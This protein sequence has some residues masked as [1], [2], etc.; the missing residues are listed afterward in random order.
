MSVENPQN[1]E[2]MREYVKIRLGHPMIE[3][4]VADQQ[5][6]VRLRQALDL[7][8]EI[9]YNSTEEVIIAHQITA[10]DVSNGF[11]QLDS[12]I[13]QVT[14]I[15]STQATIQYATSGKSKYLISFPH[16]ESG[17]ISMGGWSYG[18]FDQM[19]IRTGPG[20]PL[21][22][23][24]F[25]QSIAEN[26]LYSSSQ[27][28]FEFNLNAKRLFIYDS[29]ELVEGNYVIMRVYQILEHVKPEAVWV[30]NWLRDYAT[31]LVKLQWGINLTKFTSWRLYGEDT[32][33][34]GEFIYNEAKEEKAALEEALMDQYQVQPTI[35]IG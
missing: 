26:L 7:F 10:A 21:T 16:M 13:H 1:W 14:E 4:N 6:D 9:H 33:V 25:E 12:S 27:P 3:V 29:N 32:E 8:N 23:Y 18:Q 20:F 5:I 2:E 30:D 15:F 34:N 22:L 35:L 17:M 11:V 28:E 19:D 24:L 31:A